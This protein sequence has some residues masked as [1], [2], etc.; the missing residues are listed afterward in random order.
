MKKLYTIL[1][2]LVPL[3]MLGQDHSECPHHGERGANHSKMLENSSHYFEN[4]SNEQSFSNAAIPYVNDFGNG[5]GDFTLLINGE[6]TTNWIVNNAHWANDQQTAIG[7]ANYLQHD[8]YNDGAQENWAIT[9]TFDLSQAANPVVS[10]WEHVHW[11]N[12]ADCENPATTGLGN[13]CHEVMYSTDYTG[14]PNTAS[15]T[16]IYNDIFDNVNPDQINISP[17]NAWGDKMFDL[18]AS[19]SVTVAFKYTGNFASDWLIDDVRVYDSSAMNFFATANVSGDDVTF[20]FEIDNFVVGTGAGSDGHIHYSLNGGAEVMVYSD[21]DLTLN[22]LPNGTHTIVFSLVDNAHQPLDPPVEV[23]VTFTTFDGVFAC[24]VYGELT[25][26]NGTSGGQTFGSD[27]TGPDSSEL[28]F[29]VTPNEGETV[30]MVI[31]GETELN[32]DW[33]Y[34]TDADGTILHGPSTGPQDVTITSDTAVNVYLA[35]DGSVVRT[36]TF[37]I[38]C[39]SSTPNVTFSVNMTNY[40][41]GLAETDVVYVNGSFNNWC[42]ECNPMTD[43][44]DGTWSV[45]L[46]I[47]DGD[48]EYKF[49]VNGWSSDEQWPANGTPDCAENADNGSFENRAFSVAGEDLVLPTVY[50]NLCVGEEPSGDTVDVTFTVNTANVPG[51][52]GEG[53]MYL[54]GGIFGGANAHAMQDD[55]G[56]GTWEVTLTLESGVEGAYTFVN[57]P[58]NGDDYGGKED[59]S[60]QECAFGEWND[61]YFGPITEDTTLMH[62]YGSCESDGTCPAPPS[63]SMV[64]F[65]V[66]MNAYEGAFS[67][68]HVK[69]EF[70]G[71]SN[72]GFVMSDDDGD[73]VYSVTQELAHGTYWWKYSIDQWAG[74]ESFSEAIEGCTGNN[75]G[76]FDRQITVEGESMEASY[77]WDSC[78]A[79]GECVAA[80]TSD[81]TFSV[82]MTNYVGGLAETDVVYVNGSF[83]NW[84]GE[85]N[86]MTDNGDGTWSVT[87]PIEDGDYEYKFTVNGWSSDEQWPANGTPDCAENADNGSFENRAF[88]VAGE[89][90]VL[91]TVY[92]N[93][94]VGEEPSGDTVDVTFTVNTANVPGGVGEGGMYLGGGIFGGAN[95]HAMQDDDGDGT[96]EV[97]LT[98]ESGVEGAYT[99]VNSPANGDDYGG[100]EDISGQECAFGEWNDRYFGPI[101]EDTTL[102]HCYGSCESDGT[103]PAP[104]VTSMVTFNVNMNAYPGTFT[105][106]HVKG[107]FNGWSADGFVMSDDDGDGIYSVTQEIA[108]GTYFWKY[109]IDQWNGQESFSGESEGC[110][111]N[112]NGNFDRQITIEEDMEVSYCWNS[113]SNEGCNSA[114]QLRGIL[115]IDVSG[116]VGKGVHLYA[117]SDI[118]DLSLY[119]LGSANNQQ[120]TDG[121]EFTLSGS[122]SAGQHILVT[123]SAADA[124]GE[125]V[126]LE[127]YLSASENFN[128]IINGGGSALQGNG[129]DAY[130]LF[131]VIDGNE[132]VVE[133][134][135]VTGNVGDDSQSGDYT[136]DW[137]YRDSWAYK[138]AFG[139]WT[140]AGIDCTDGSTTTCESNCPYPFVSCDTSEEVIDFLVS[141]GN[142]R[143]MAEEGGHMGVGPGNA[144]NAAWWN[145]D[146]WVKAY[147]GL[148]DD[149]WMFDAEGFMTH[150]TGDDGT[151]FGKKPAIDA[152]F[153]ENTPYDADI[154]PDSGNADN[155]EYHNYPLAT[156]T[157]SYSVSTLGDYD[158]IT[159][160]SNGTIGFYTATAGQEYQILETGEGYMYLRNVG[161]DGNSWY[162]KFTNAEYL[163]TSNNEILDMRI[164]PN[165][166]NGNY[167]TILTPVEGLKEIEVYSVT[168]RRILNTTINNNTLDVSSLNSGFYMIKVTIDGQSKV[169]KLIVR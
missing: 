57:S 107:E 113:C 130:E 8:D 106:V 144:F 67:T 78:S 27:F 43:N 139:I 42:G 44:G 58:A 34:V 14:D 55:D 119:G 88:S 54:G 135:G 45:T 91:P 85:C 92:W 96:W 35:T 141:A 33:I 167:V 6:G 65:N 154:D 76:N 127:G 32:W 101:T 29:T 100:K 129:N 79:P 59:I 10:F 97:T 148:Y 83:N 68:V 125:D 11:A 164:Y 111:V 17:T 53:G 138:D 28:E 13:G 22:D 62:C 20:S 104:P 123:N 155:Q 102:M 74:Q 158:T 56:D 52:V 153:P 133:T 121:L 163:S 9:P 49:T 116:G 47:E 48:Y 134:F 165:P 142:W 2:V 63:T 1:F 39:A 137:A 105:T 93:L 66:D 70:N 86:P 84:C 124:T 30:T 145:A 82:N 50:W 131:E 72:D 149:G 75:F 16:V 64:T 5:V 71:W 37:D 18:P 81:V 69:G 152:A 89:D 114:L 61:R 126:F 122:V 15:W 51:G 24:G 103:C 19:A 128:L 41:G 109:S 99:F 40:V 73:G 77:C 108:N 117:V 98:L 36:L 159:L 46:P 3:M 156:Y 132:V 151:I 115:D 87:L 168:G 160:G 94:C 80:T 146:P 25:Y 150:D 118:A 90:L 147:T 110:T 169:S 60:G 95:A 23:E 112:N 31:G 7:N 4:H 143:V 38:A 157:D 140:Y 136:M 162:G 166:V 26:E 12:Y 120:G 161:Q 21:G